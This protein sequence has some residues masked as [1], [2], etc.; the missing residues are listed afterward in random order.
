MPPP[1]VKRHE[2]DL[3]RPADHVQDDP[4]PLVAGGDV[5][6]DQ[7]VGPLRLVARGDLDRVARV[8]EVDEV[9]PLDHAAALTS[10]QGMIRLASMRSPIAA[11]P[12][13]KPALGAARIRLGA[14]S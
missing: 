4:A 6:E 5:E 10:R 14:G 11:S 12:A 13:A 9:R 3:G 1:T 2:A 7:L 8:A